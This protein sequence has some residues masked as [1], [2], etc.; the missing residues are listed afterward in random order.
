MSSRKGASLHQP[1][2]AV[3]AQGVGATGD[4]ED[5]ADVWVRQHVDPAV[6]PLVAGSF[7]HGD[8]GVVEDVHEAGRV[9]LRR[10]VAG[11]VGAGR[12][13]QQER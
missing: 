3:D 8:R 4:H 1:G 2:P 9:A 13:H 5:Q 6:G 10:D 12:R 11:A 7:R